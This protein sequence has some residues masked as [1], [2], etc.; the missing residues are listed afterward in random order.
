LADWSPPNSVDGNRPRIF[1]QVSDP[2]LVM[3]PR[4]VHEV[5]PPHQQIMPQMN[6]NNLKVQPEK[7]NGEQNQINNYQNLRGEGGDANPKPF[8][9]YY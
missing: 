1:A 9:S 6:E 8:G 5:H 4:E 7:Q 2:M 3:Q